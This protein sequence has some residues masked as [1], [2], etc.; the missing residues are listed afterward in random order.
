MKIIVGIADMQVSNDPAATLITYSLGSCIGVAI[1]DPAVRVA[2]MLHFML[3]DSKIDLQKA[4][5][6]P[7]MFADT[8][9]P[10]LFKETYKF[11]AEKQR[12]RVK[13]AGGS[14]I[15]DESGF[16]NIG[17]RNYMVLRK[18]FWAN[19]VLIHAE[20]IGGSINRTLSVEI[21]S[22]K[23]FVKTSGDGTNEI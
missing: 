17:K 6:N 18:I 21:A 11:G 16:F 10:D 5:K 23:V 2:G 14:Q 20:D 7:W 12:M 8:G 3:P 4:Q 13:I 9:I 15:L 1:Y 19:N 22:G